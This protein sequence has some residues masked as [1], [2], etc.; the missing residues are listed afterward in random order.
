MDSPSA[1]IA[2]KNAASIV[3]T[4][5]CQYSIATIKNGRIGS[6]RVLGSAEVTLHVDSF[7]ANRLNG[8]YLLSPKLKPDGKLMTADDKSK[9]YAYDSLLNNFAISDRVA[10]TTEQWDHCRQK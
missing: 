9:V 3:K 7:K 6:L 5:L 8:T 10:R 1:K 2:E 4:Y